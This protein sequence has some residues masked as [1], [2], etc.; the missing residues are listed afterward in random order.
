MAEVMLEDE[1]EKED[2]N[3]EI[4][5]IAGKKT[6]ENEVPEDFGALKAKKQLQ[7]TD[8]FVVRKIN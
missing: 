4:E 5:E 1:C 2:F 3:D 8:F 6:D 7:M